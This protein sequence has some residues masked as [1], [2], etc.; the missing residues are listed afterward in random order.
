MFPGEPM[1]MPVTSL[2]AALMAAPI[3]SAS[4]SIDLVELQVVEVLLVLSVDRSVVRNDPAVTCEP[5]RSTPIAVRINTLFRNAEGRT[6]TGG[7]TCN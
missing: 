2:P 3:R 7:R 4:T 5:P 1:P 6:R